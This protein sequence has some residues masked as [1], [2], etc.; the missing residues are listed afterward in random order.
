M[1]S[2]L[3]RRRGWSATRCGW[4]RA[5][6][7]RRTALV[8]DLVRPGLTHLCG[9]ADP[10]RP[11]TRSRH[12]PSTRQPPG[13]PRRRRLG[14]A[15]RQDPAR[16]AFRGRGSR[17]RARA[18]RGVL[19][20][21]R[22]DSALDHHAAQSLALGNAVRRRPRVAARAAGSTL[23]DE[24]LRR[25]GRRR[26]PRVHRRVRSRPRQPGLE[27]LQRLRPVARRH[28]C[29]CADRAVRGPGLRVRGRDRRRRVARRLRPDRRR[30]LARVG[31]QPQRA[32]PR[33][34]LDRRLS[35]HCP[36]RLQA[37]R[38]KPCLQHGSS[39]GHRHPRRGRGSRCRAAAQPAP[40]STAV[41]A[42]EPSRRR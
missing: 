24:G 30:R 23:L 32:L 11:A 33:Q 36:R 6:S 15:T 3:A 40:I 5:L 13:H 35:S 22:R 42:C 1:G 38:G 18:P 17:R 21:P 19:R 41:S 14:R 16:A 39:A 4:G 27:G 10:D 26:L 31:R 12:T 28:D 8:P 7:R 37:P 9:H 34:F 20:N 29:Q 2:A 25:S